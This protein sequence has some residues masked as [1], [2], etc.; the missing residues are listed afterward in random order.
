MKTQSTYLMLRTSVSHLVTAN[1]KKDTQSVL[2]YLVYIGI[3]GRS[4]PTDDHSGHFLTNP[5]H[6]HNPK[7]GTR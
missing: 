1:S 4:A 6:H 2:I 7:E 3:R 5:T